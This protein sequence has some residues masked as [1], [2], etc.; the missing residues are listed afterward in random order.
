VWNVLDVRSSTKSARA[1]PLEGAEKS[2]GSFLVVL[3]F[4]LA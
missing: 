4:A 2:I 3:Y 1:S